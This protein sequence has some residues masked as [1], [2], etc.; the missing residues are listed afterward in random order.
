[1][2]TQPLQM[3][4]SSSDRDN[5]RNRRDEVTDEAAHK[6]TREHRASVLADPAN[7]LPTCTPITRVMLRPV[8]VD[9]V[10]AILNGRENVSRDLI[11][12]AEL[13]GYFS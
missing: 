2:E 1:M 12:G 5:G 11:E 7:V 6:A 9:V 4:R 10:A 13:M 8:S 3:D